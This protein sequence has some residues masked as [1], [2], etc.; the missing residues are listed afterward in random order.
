MLLEIGW[1]EF[2][3]RGDRGRTLLL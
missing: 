3:E 1:D 2:A